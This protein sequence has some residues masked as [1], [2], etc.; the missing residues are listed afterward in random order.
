MTNKKQ[1]S[2]KNIKKIYHEQAKQEQQV[3]E[4]KIEQ[5]E[6]LPETAPIV[7]HKSEP[8]KV[9]ESAAAAVDEFLAALG[10]T[11]LVE[12]VSTAP[13]PKVSIPAS[14][15]DDTTKH[16]LLE[17]IQE[18]APTPVTPLTKQ[19]VDLTKP[20]TSKKTK[21]TLDPNIKAINDRLG[22][23]EK[24]LGDLAVRPIGQ[25]PGGGETRLR[26]L[27]DIDR[28]TIADGLYLRY[29]ATTKKFEFADPVSISTEEDTLDSVTDRGNTT[30]NDIYVNSLNVPVGSVISG[31]SEI[32]ATITN[33]A[34]NAV[35]E[36]GNSAALDIGDYGLT[37]GITGVPYTVYEL[38]AVPSPALQVN[39]IIGGAAIPVLSKILFVGTGIYNKIIIT[40]K[41]FAVGATL[42]PENTIITF[43]REIVNAGLSLSTDQ[44]TDITLNPGAG[45]NI[46]PH[47][48]IIPY[49]TNIWSLGTP[50]KRFKELWLGT[51]TIYVQDETLGNDQALGARDGNFYIQGGA[52]LEVGEW[53]LRD[54]NLL[55]KDPTRDVYIG[56]IGATADVIFNRAIKVE[57]TAGRE[58]FSVARSGLTTITTPDT[59]LT[60]QSAL[61]IVGSSSGNQYPRNFTGTLLQM[62]AQDGQSARLSMDTFGGTTNTY[63][64][65]AGRAAR[66]T[67]DAPTATQSG[68]TLFRI[69]V[70][71]YGTTDFVSSIGRIALA[72]KQTFTDSEAGTE[73]VFQTTPLNS[74]T[75]GTS[76]KIDDSGLV[77]TGT[78][79][80]NSGIT[81]RDG[82]RLKYFPSPAGK[83]GYHLGTDGT[84]IFWEAE[85]VIEGSV[86]FK[87]E[88]N[89][90]TN[91]PTVSD[92]TGTTGWQYI[93]SVAGT[94]NLG[95]GSVAY[96]V[97]DQIIHDGTKY[98]RIPAQS[99]QIQSNWTE[100]N[101][102]APAYIQ[103]KPTLFSGS[104]T[105][106]TNKP[107][108][109]APQLQSDWNQTNNLSLDFIKNK[110]SIPA[111]YTL[112]AATTT[113]LGGVIVPAVGTSGISNS[114]GTIGLAT[115][116]TTQL[117][118]V[119]VDGTSITIN[120]GVISANS[121]FTSTVTTQAST[122][123]VDFEGSSVIFWQPSANGN[124]SITLSN[125]TAGK[126]VRIFI[127]PHRNQDTF[128]FTGV[129]GSHCSNGSNAF[130]LAGGGAAQTSMMIEIFS[131]TDAIGGVWIFANGGV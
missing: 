19:V 114:S 111:T 116:T 87:G 41:N 35:L 46:V 127:T 118:G 4:V 112:P 62:T 8:V 122:L 88:W 119:K 72:A 76:A 131:T 26:F 18:E 90:S 3:V 120:D 1:L 42:P 85:T 80:A 40:D 65:I 98:I 63:G 126:S 105:D 15:F 102:S 10:A 23:F 123:A 70:Q 43:A 39:D 117:G 57:T 38:K 47:A 24:R 44:D 78:T 124:R 30:N 99:A 101:T 84:D 128:T 61:N 29:N 68:D 73:V 13:I 115:A 86:V 48:D 31:A 59:L 45:G 130:S 92:A 12:V 71:G 53:T 104:Y 91:T 36:N 2:F 60:T 28:S 89:A 55:I 69:S 67:I 50:G 9:T 81:F 56:T 37:N 93:V 5:L 94:Q 14:S 11:N 20:V 95:G 100:T 97:G 129:T 83:A 121:T 74:T 77:L 25:D 7:E 6:V 125:F 54:N 79:N 27:D 113:T 16:D 32:I 21:P 34:L 58:S 109:P 110:P 22:F 106:L 108:I 75:I 66:G 103:N 33:A 96:G 64:L 51:G 107:T 17:N 82:S 49:T 52:G